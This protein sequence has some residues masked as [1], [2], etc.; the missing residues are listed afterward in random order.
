MITPKTLKLSVKALRD[1]AK[2]RLPDE[3]L[4]E[5]DERDECPLD[6][7]RYMCDP[8]RLGI[9]LLFIPEEYGGLGGGAFDAYCICEAMART[10]PGPAPPALPTYLGSDTITV[11]ATPE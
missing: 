3:T 5:L 6:I 8:D 9:Q 7:V 4:I 10:H 2:K 1:F 11:G